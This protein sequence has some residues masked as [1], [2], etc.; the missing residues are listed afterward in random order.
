[1]YSSFFKKILPHVIAIVVF[2][3]IAMVYCRP[4]MQGD[5]LP[6]SD[7]QHWQGANKQ[8]LDFK[9]KYGHYPLW[10]NSVFS[11]MPTFMI[12]FSG[13]N[14]LPWQFHSAFTLGLPEPVQ[15]FF[16]ACICFYF[17]GLVL[18]VNSYVSMFGSIAFAYATYNPI[19]IS[20][21]HVTKMLS[22]AYMP[23]LL[24]AVLLIYK[25][26]YLV[27]VASTALFSS[28]L[29]AMN[30]LQIDYYLFLVIAIMTLFFLVRGIREGQWKN[31]IVSVLLVMAGGLTGA[32]VNAVTLLST[33]EYQKE[34]IRGGASALTENVKSGEK[35][36]GLDKDYAFSY[37]IYPTESFTIM[38]PRI[39]GGS[40]DKDEKGEDAHALEVLSSLPRELQSQL[41][42]SY[43]W[44]GIGYTSGPP[45]VGAIVC[46]LAILGLFMLDGKH[47]W[48]IATAVLITIIMAWGSY[49][50][51]FNDLLF[52][53]LPLYNKFRAPSMI[54]V[55]PQLLLPLLAVL[56][57]NLFFTQENKEL[58]WPAFK[59]GLIATGG[60]FV[61]AFLLYSSFDFQSDSD[62]NVLSQVRQMNQPQLTEMISS[63]FNALREDRKELFY[64]DIFRSLGF[65]LLAGGALWLVIR[66]KMTPLAATLAIL[67]LSFSDVM[68]INTKY[69]NVSQYV[70]A[71]ENKAAH[72]TVTPADAEILKDNDYFRVFNAT[73][74]AFS[75]NNTSYYHNSVGGY[76]AAKL[77][78]YQDLIDRQL[79]KSPMNM[80]VFDML[81]TKYFILNDQATG[82]KRA[83]INPGAMGNAWLVEHIR[84]VENATEAMDALNNF[85]PRDTA[86]VEKEFK[87]AVPFMPVADSS[88]SIKLVENRNDTLL[89][90]FSAA[91]NQ[92]AVFSEIYYKNGW[93]A[94]IDGKEAPIVKVNY[95]LRGLAVPAGKHSIEFRFEPPLYLLGRK[96][97]S[98]SS[99]LMLLLMLGAAVSIVVHLRKKKTT[100]S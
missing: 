17:L 30:H 95:L 61:V 35:Q 10:T 78:L 90:E 92:F 14:T 88:A 56:T 80:P 74:N 69:L 38:F 93:K 12:A 60:V 98:F 27:G 51:S 41:P 73:A 44:G 54:L 20:V 34:T 4:A 11:G 79:S 53:Y 42:L 71:D 84:F 85:N 18:G 100:H 5:V 86:V 68:A 96:M 65:I 82:A 24:G 76:H 57:V 83:Q 43:Y 25:R 32:A 3:V 23:A 81:N 2:L 58:L 37:S 70:E 8:S 49:F 19:I 52:K 46:F 9:E 66:K 39:Y 1:M 33:Y 91:S 50:S 75:E 47:K 6:Q 48:W 87:S 64:K 97:T 22:I 15:F 7:I 99:M 26:K 89:Y 67:V 63:F 13:N 36:T 59:K 40:S 55:I 29:I 77:R 72:F 45:Y 94:F 28:I 21:G 16:L 31:V 62:R